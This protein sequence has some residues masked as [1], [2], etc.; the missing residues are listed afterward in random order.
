MSPVLPLN[1]N[2]ART[3]APPVMEARRWLAETARPEGLALLNLSQAAPVDPPPLELREAIAEAALT[4]AE[5]HLYGPVLGNGDLRA[6]VAGRWS[7]HYGAPVAPEEVGIT[8]GCNQ[9]F[10]TAL[11][12]ACAPGEKVILPAPWYFN[13]K[14]WCDMAGVEVVPA[15]CGEGCLPDLDALARLAAEPGVRALVLVTPNNPTGRSIPHR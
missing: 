3:F 6:A 4:R 12:T 1:P 14:M 15:P 13:H 2:L 5:A 10:C 7:A 9:A 8:S 11:A